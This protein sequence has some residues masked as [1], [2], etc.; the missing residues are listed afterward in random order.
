MYSTV[1]IGLF[2][3]S[4]FTALSALSLQRRTDAYAHAAVLPS[5]SVLNDRQ[6]GRIYSRTVS[7]YIQNAIG[8]N[9]RKGARVKWDFG[10]IS[11]FNSTSLTAAHATSSE[12]MGM[13]MLI[14][15]FAKD[16][17]RFNKLLQFYIAARLPNNRALMPWLVWSNGT[18]VLSTICIPRCQPARG[19]D[20]RPH[21]DIDVAMAL[22]IASAQ[23][24]DRIVKYKSHAVRILNHISKHWVA[25]CKRRNSPF[26]HMFVL[27]DKKTGF[28]GSRISPWHYNPA[29]FTYFASVKGVHNQNKWEALAHTS[30]RLYNWKK[31]RGKMFIPDTLLL[32][33]NS[34]DSTSFSYSSARVPLFLALDYA[35][36]GTPAAK[37]YSAALINDLVYAN[38]KTLRSIRGPISGK[39]GR[40]VKGNPRSFRAG[41]AA[42]AMIAGLNN[43]DAFARVFRNTALTSKIPWN[44]RKGGGFNDSYNDAYGM[45][46]ATL[47]AL[48]LTGN[49]RHPSLLATERSTARTPEIID[50]EQMCEND[51]QYGFLKRQVRVKDNVSLAEMLNSK[52]RGK[53]GT[54]ELIYLAEQFHDID[55]SIQEMNKREFN[56]RDC[57]RDEK[58]LKSARKFVRLLRLG[59]NDRAVLR[60]QRRHE[61]AG[62]QPEIAVHP[63]VGAG[64]HAQPLDFQA[65]AE[66][67][68]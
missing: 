16:K 28:C 20:P 50:G 21:A 26:Y 2:L 52:G 59:A 6:L 34:T 13:A 8:P 25:A 29:F 67:H 10:G 39:T 53:N 1:I 30:Y 63:H 44:I 3:A 38:G 64:A 5:K 37:N 58:T 4:S 45:S 68:V 40:S 54:T 57:N 61:G 18:A 31:V 51:G 7:R 33:A 42:A 14:T 65:S 19:A 27:R 35:W 23:W 9:S 11:V 48:A 12:G 32:T 60:H 43:V 49:S 62:I 41:F 17:G 46:M 55:A 24:G 22:L 47:A 66:Q 36:H 56:R 15:A